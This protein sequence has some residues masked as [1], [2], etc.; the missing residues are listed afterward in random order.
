M[1]GYNLGKICSHI[2]NNEPE[3][4][5]KR[6]NTYI[7]EKVTQKGSLAIS[8]LRKI[9]KI[10]KSVE[11]EIGSNYIEKQVIISN[12]KEIQEKL[13]SISKI[14]KEIISISE[15]LKFS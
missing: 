8:E 12:D 1:S 15:D 7:I 6:K 3:I 14:S 9:E 13:D 4:Q 10:L 5:P 2:I 11:E